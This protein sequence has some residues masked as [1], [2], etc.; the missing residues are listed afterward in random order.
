[1]MRAV[2][3]WQVYLSLVLAAAA[4]LL[5][6]WA[7]AWHNRM[8]PDPMLALTLTTLAVLAQHVPLTL[9][10]E[11]KASAA[12]AVYFAALLLFGAPVAMVF[13]FVC[14]TLGGLT[15]FLRRTPTTRKPRRTI[16]N[17]V[18]NASQLSLAVGL[19]SLVYYAWLPQTSPALL[20]GIANL[21]A[22]PITATVLYLVNSGAVA[23]MVGL[24]TQQN[25]VDVWRTNRGLATMEAAGLLLLGLIVAVLA[26]QYPWAPLLLVPPTA[27]YQRSLQHTIELLDKNQDVQR[28]LAHQAF[29]DPLTDIANRALF[30]ERLARWSPRSGAVL[31]LDVDDFKTINDRLGH[32]AG[33]QL[34]VAV[35]RRLQ[36]CLPATDTL[37]R[38]G[39]DEFTIL[40][41]DLPD[42]ETT[43]RIAERIIRTV[44]APITI[45][46]GDVVVTV[47]IGI[48]H[49]EAGSNRDDLLLLA[50]RALY[51]AKVSG[52][53][54]YA[55]SGSY[56]QATMEST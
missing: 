10:P 27:L 31:C 50:D 21:W 17:V 35:A 2:H 48:V 44:Q 29:H 22:L 36:R 16:T 33:D 53:G 8:L 20:S 49:A 28:Q 1:M 30:R 3:S 12:V 15:L 46:G 23:V 52:K 18:F 56:S 24:H 55:V 40:L 51:Q 41:N 13:T 9:G 32:A 43:V 26:A 42:V 45:E 47:S 25:P 38:M 14:Q 34:L 19:A 6:Y 7:G 37:A 4:G 39:G 54:Q 11:R 5:T